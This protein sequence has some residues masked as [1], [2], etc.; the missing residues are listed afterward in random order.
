MGHIKK[1]LAIGDIG[2]RLITSN[3]V[4]S[5]L[6]ENI[7]F[8]IRNMRMDMSPK[9]W[10]HFLSSIHNLGMA[11][12]YNIEKF[13][14]RAG[15]PNFEV[16]LCYDNPVTSNT[17]YFPNRVTIELQKD[18]TIHFHYRDIRLHWSLTEF[19]AIARM[20]SK[21]LFDY[22]HIEEFPYK[23]VTE[24]TLF[25]NVPIDL[26]QPYDAGHLPGVIDR[27][28]RDGIDYAKKL[29]ESCE[30][31][32]PILVSTDGTRLDGFKRYMAFKELG[33]DRID[34]YVDPFGIMGGQ[35]NQSMVID[36]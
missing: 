35:S 21:A 6:C 8:H 13:D 3:M 23:D 7:H 1:L 33:H 30:K 18:N 34:I 14:W 26:I 22:E 32:R 15:D 12:E 16:Q 9:E 10:S 19:K 4:W 29:I 24:K 36:E 11:V 2:P 25:E 28:H 27:E 31:I 17:E 5:D 20:F